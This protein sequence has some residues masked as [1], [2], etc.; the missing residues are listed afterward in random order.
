MG[1]A[2]LEVGS[3][4]RLLRVSLSADL[5]PSRRSQVGLSLLALELNLGCTRAGSCLQR[6]QDSRLWPRNGG[7]EAQPVLDYLELGRQ[8][9]ALGP[10]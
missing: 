6:T 10:G 8:T 4:R 1:L 3:Q 7:L 5:V 2:N 9:G